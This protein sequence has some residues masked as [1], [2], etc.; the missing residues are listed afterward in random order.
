VLAAALL[1]ACARWSP[2]AP[3][4]LEDTQWQLASL[5]GASLD[6]P[7]EARPGLIFRQDAKQV[8]GFGGCNRFTGSY[9]VE[10]ELILLGPIASTRMA[11]ARGMEVER[12]FYA[13]LSRAARWEI[14]GAHL[15]LLDAAGRMVAQFEPAPQ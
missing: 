3:V 15:E 6:I 13:A 5:A 12:A 1:A 11:C 14:A 4:P 2:P 7:P 8:S 9:T 10:G